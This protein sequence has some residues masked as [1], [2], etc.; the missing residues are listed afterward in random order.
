MSHNLVIDLGLNCP[1]CNASDLCAEDCICPACYISPAD[2]QRDANITAWRKYAPLLTAL[3]ENDIHWGWTTDTGNCAAH[4]YLIEIMGDQGWMEIHRW[5]D[6]YV[7]EAWKRTYGSRERN[8][9]PEAVLLDSVEA[10]TED[11]ALNWVDNARH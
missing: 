3:T 4:K 9:A 10:Y 6:H 8:E 2:A 11:E 1:S 5:G 7:C